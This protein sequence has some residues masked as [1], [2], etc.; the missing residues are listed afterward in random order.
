MSEDV[1]TNMRGTNGQLRLV[2]DIHGPNLSF[3]DVETVDEA[4]ELVLKR[5]EEIGRPM[6]NTDYGLG[7]ILDTGPE[8]WISLWTDP[9][10]AVFEAYVARARLERNV[11]DDSP[12]EEEEE[13]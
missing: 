6:L 7:V 2:M 8:S 10:G 9:N 4:I 3:H 13:V 1:R 12:L 11:R 5:E